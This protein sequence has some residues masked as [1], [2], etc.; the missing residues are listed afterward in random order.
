MVNGQFL[1]MHGGISSFLTGVDAINKIDRKMEPPEE[2]CLLLDLLWA[3]PA[4]NYDKD[5]IEYEE[6]TKRCV[7][8]VF[9]K[10][11]INELLQKENLKAIVRAHEC[12]Q[13]GYKMHLWNG[14]E[15]FPPVITVFSAP[16]YCGTYE[17]RAGIIISEGEEIDIKVFTEKANKPYLLPNQPRVDAFTFF[18]EEIVAFALNQ[19]YRIC[20][21]AAACLD[22]NLDQAL[23]KTG[24]TDQKYKDLI[25]N[26]SKGDEKMS[27]VKEDQKDDIVEKDQKLNRRQSKIQEVQQ[28]RRLT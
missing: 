20:R 15:E 3:D 7:S 21:N 18:H 22:D 28:I 2:D 24:T 17:N 26:I 12:K 14:E 4:S 6:N 19:L 10:R 23:T 9:G 27:Q 13:E 16:N 5:N 11:P 8:V 25:E 1:C